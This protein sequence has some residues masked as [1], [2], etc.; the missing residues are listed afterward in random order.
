MSLS[1]PDLNTRGMRAFRAGLAREL[2]SWEASGLITGPA[3]EELRA[4]YQL[5]AHGAVEATAAFYALGAALILGG[6]VSFIAWHWATMSPA[7]RLATMGSVM[8][9]CHAAGFWLW[10]IDGRLPKLGHALWAIGTLVFG[11]NIGLVA[12]VFHIS[13]PWYRGVGT[14]AVGALVAGAL[15]GSVP[16]LALATAGGVAWEISYTQEHVTQAVLLPYLILAIGLA[17]ARW[18]RSRSLFGIAAAGWM[19]MVFSG[20]VVSSTPPD[21]PL[22]W[23]MLA[24]GALMIAVSL[25][26]PGDADRP[27]GASP[28]TSLF[29]VQSAAIAERLGTVAIVVTAYVCTFISLHNER[30]LAPRMWVPAPWWACVAPAAIA[31]LAFLLL[32]DRRRMR[33][34]IDAAPVRAVAL[35]GAAATA[36]AATWAGSVGGIAIVI[37][38]NATVAAIAL[39][40]IASSVRTLERGAFWMGVTLS[41]VLIL[42]R[43][44]QYETTLWLKAMAFL[45]CGV[46]VIAAAGL[47]ER[48]LRAPSLAGEVPRVA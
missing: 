20:A 19:A 47:F 13:G 41:G 25:L 35:A 32:G 46:A 5:D 42:S 12:Q 37:A 26:F 28:E 3:R 9:L 40:A 4:R 17:L 24:A 30:L 44:M 15:M 33:L 11:A 29:L 34:R 14:W 39:T 10:R 21:A 6:V 45:S 7:A 16:V 43:F 38:A 18:A 1:V 48:R 31:T 36:L 27:S 23:T 22:I 2:D 8:V